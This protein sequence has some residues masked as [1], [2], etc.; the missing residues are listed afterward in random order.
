MKLFWASWLAL[1]LSLAF[2]CD[3]SNPDDPVGAYMAFVH[4][5]QK[6]DAK[7]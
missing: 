7:V 5:S 6:Q 4:A 1:A 2:A 3:R